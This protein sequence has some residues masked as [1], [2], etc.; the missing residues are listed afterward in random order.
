[1]PTHA[2]VIQAYFQNGQ[3]NIQFSKFHDLAEPESKYIET[4]NNF[5]KLADAI[6]CSNTLAVHGDAKLVEEFHV[7]FDEKR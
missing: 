1:M 4:M 2:R 3:L 7:V 6:P 5:L